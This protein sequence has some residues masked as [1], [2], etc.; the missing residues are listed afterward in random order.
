[1]TAAETRWIALDVG[2]ANIK[3]AHSSCQ[4]RT[5]PFE[6]WKRP[7]ELPRVLASLTAAFPPADFAAVTMHRLWEGE[8][9]AE[10][11]MSMDAQ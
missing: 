1:M 10:P 9:P 2:G 8:A 6:L 3:A 5:L 7:D 11:R 4:A